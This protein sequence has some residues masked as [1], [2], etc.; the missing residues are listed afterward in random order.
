MLKQIQKGFTLIELMIVV[1]IIGILAAIAIPAYQDYVIRSQVSEG[2]AIGLGVTRP[3]WPSTSLTWH[4]AGQQQLCSASARQP[5]EQYVSGI[6][7]QTR[8]NS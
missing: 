8:H 1:A 7:R 3:R 2:F 5:T 6:E 4:L